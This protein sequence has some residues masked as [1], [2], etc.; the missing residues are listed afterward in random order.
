MTPEQFDDLVGEIV[1]GLPPEFQERL[2][3]VAVLVREEP[4]EEQLR[5]VGCPPG[6]TLL[7]LYTGVPM[8]ERGSWQSGSLPDTIL[9]FRGPI[10][11]ACGGDPHCVARQVRETVLHEIAHYFGITDARLRELG[12]H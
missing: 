6:E 2:W 4:T 10:E 9:I 1:D 11:R 3:N 5:S 8:T 7:G 12:L